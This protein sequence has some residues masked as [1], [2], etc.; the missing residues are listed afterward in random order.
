MSLQ[1]KKKKKKAKAKPKKKPGKPRAARRPKQEPPTKSYGKRETVKKKAAFLEAYSECGS[2]YH[3][4]K[5]AC[6]GRSTA[7]RW[8][9]EDKAF[10]KEL[11]EA[12]AI[13]TDHLEFTAFK[14]SIGTPA[15][16]NKKGKRIRAERAGSDTLLIFLL[17]SRKPEKYA[18]RYKHE[19]K[20]Q[21]A[22]FRD[23][24]LY[25]QQGGATQPGSIP[26]EGEEKPKALS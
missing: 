20:G 14:R 3:S 11:E 16:F 18:E 13:N 23:F 9:G 12:Y 21:G 8:Q 17:K 26:G 1:R 19:H 24:L 25:W 10:A 7:Y 5:A 2:V 22:T 6:I 15:V 4:C